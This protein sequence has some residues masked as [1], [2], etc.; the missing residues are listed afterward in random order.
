MR[1]LLTGGT[2]YIGSAVLERLVARDHDVTAVVRSEASGEKVAG[3]GATPLLGDL[4]DTSWLTRQL[5]AHDGAVHTAA[6]GDASDA[7]LND[8][9]VEAVLAAYSGTDRPFVHTGGIWTHGD[10]RHI[11]ESSPAEPVALTA[12]RVDDEERLLASPVRATVI[13]PGI[14]YGHGAGIP[15]A[16]LVEGPRNA[17]GALVLPGS[18]EQ[19]WTTV[20]VDDLAELYALVVETSPGGPVIAV[21][22]DSPTVRTLGEAAA[23]HVAPSTADATRERLGAAFADALLLDQQGTGAGAR[24]LGWSPSRRSLV[25][26]LRAL[27]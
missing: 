1:I 24:A 19:H 8:A 14:V 9:V 18:G 6:A 15:Q 25:D 7:A 13:R 27:R 17:D 2:G 5:A 26:E 22:G 12:W 21:S 3:L 23:G 4:T 10:N 20:H 16:L 11:T